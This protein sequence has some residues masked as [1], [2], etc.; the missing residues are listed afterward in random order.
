MEALVLTL[1]LTLTL[2][3]NAGVQG[4]QGS[5]AR[6]ISPEAG[7]ACGRQVAA[8]RDRGNSGGV[9]RCNEGGDAGSRSGEVE[10]EVTP[11]GGVVDG[12]LGTDR[13]TVQGTDRDGVL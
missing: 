12:T 11:A 8:R 9:A 2:S 1:A 5:P 3:P 4:H 7:A 13:G 6:P 10:M